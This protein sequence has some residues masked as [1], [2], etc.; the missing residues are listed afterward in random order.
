MSILRL[1]EISYHYKGTQK[2]VLNKISCA[3]ETGRLYCITGD[4]GEGKTTLLSLIAG[5]DLCSSGRIYYE[6][7]DIAWINRDEYRSKKV[8]V[9]FQS[10]HLLQNATVIENLVLSMNVAGKR[11]KQTAKDANP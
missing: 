11:G 7:Q 10:Y 8:G 3:F 2:T 1:E 5:L 9:V 6:A 4:S